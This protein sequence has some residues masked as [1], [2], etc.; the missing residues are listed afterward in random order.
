MMA[1]VPGSIQNRPLAGESSPVVM[2][3]GFSRSL[4]SSRMSPDFNPLL[5]AGLSGMTSEMSTPFVSLAPN[6][7]ASSG[8][9]GWIDTPS[10][11]RVTFPLAT[12]SV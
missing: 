9:R 12:S 4:N 6:D 8:V 10:H 5:L 2:M 7:L 3:R 1:P 11:P